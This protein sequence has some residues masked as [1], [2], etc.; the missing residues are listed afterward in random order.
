M[1]VFPPSRQSPRSSENGTTSETLVG[2]LLPAFVALHFVVV[3]NLRV[4]AEFMH[5]LL[6]I[7]A[8]VGS[9]S[10]LS[11]NGEKVS[12]FMNEGFLQ[13]LFIDEQHLAESD[14]VKVVVGDP[15]RYAQVLPEE[16]RTPIK[17][18]LAH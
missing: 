10:A 9:L 18:N 11:L 2:N 1:K 4:G 5:R 17:G 8:M 6:P 7:L 16:N 15:R 3:S 13:T 12:I 14:L